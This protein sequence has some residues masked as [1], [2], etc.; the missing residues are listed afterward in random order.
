MSIPFCYVIEACR[1]AREA[2]GKMNAAQRRA[3]LEEGKRI[4]NSA[5]NEK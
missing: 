3:L 1:E 4:I 2:V 5:S